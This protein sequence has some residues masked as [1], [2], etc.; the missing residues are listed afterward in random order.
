M[1]KAPR[2]PEAEQPPSGAR[3]AKSSHWAPRPH[4]LPTPQGL[5]ARHPNPSPWVRTEPPWPAR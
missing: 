3:Q 1:R 4:L 5:A 2:F